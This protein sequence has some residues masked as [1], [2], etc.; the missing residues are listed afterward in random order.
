MATFKKIVLYLFGII[1]LI[2][3]NRG[4]INTLFASEAGNKDAEPTT[5]LS[6]SSAVD[7]DTTLKDTTETKQAVPD[8]VAGKQTEKRVAGDVK[9]ESASDASKQKEEKVTKPETK[10]EP[11]KKEEASGTE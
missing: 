11:A 10:V 4:A 9:A 1:L 5:P 8:R 7:A 6:P 2:F 3:G